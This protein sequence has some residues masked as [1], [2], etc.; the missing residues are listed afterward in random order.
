MAQQ[1][2]VPGTPGSKLPDILPDSTK[3]VVPEFDNLVNWFGTGRYS[4]LN[5]QDAKTVDLETIVMKY[6]GTNQQFSDIVILPIISAG[7]WST[8]I[9]PMER[10]LTINFTWKRIY[11]QN[12]MLDPEPELATAS[13]VSHTQ[14]ELK[15]TMTRW[16]KKARIGADYYKLKD[17][18]ELMNFQVIQLSTAA[19]NTIEQLIERTIITSKRYWQDW[20][21][22][23]GPRSNSVI[24]ASMDEIDLFGICSDDDKGFYKLLAYVRRVMKAGPFQASMGIFKQG[25]LDFLALTGDFETNSTKVGIEIAKS[26]LLSAG[27]SFKGTFG[28]NIAIYEVQAANNQIQGDGLSNWERLVTIG[29][30]AVVNGWTQ[31]KCYNGEQGTCRLSE[32]YDFQHISMDIDGYKTM[33]MKWARRRSLRFDEK[34]RLS[35]FLSNFLTKIFDVAEA[36]GIKIL[37]EAVDPYIW[38]SNDMK[39]DDGESQANN[40][41]HLCRYVGDFETRYFTLEQQA[42]HG[43]IAA[44]VIKRDLTAEDYSNMTKMA[45]LR[46]QLASPPDLDTSVVGLVLATAFMKD[47]IPHADTPSLT[48]RRNQLTGSPV[49]PYRARDPL[50]TSFSYLAEDGSDAPDVRVLW[51][52]YQD[53]EIDFHQ[54]GGTGQLT[55]AAGGV[56][57][58]A[59]RTVLRAQLGGEKFPIAYLWAPK[60][61]FANGGQ[62]PTNVLERSN[63]LNGNLP[64]DPS[65]IAGL[66]GPSSPLLPTINK[67]NYVQSGAYGGT[68]VGIGYAWQTFEGIDV[69]AVA[70]VNDPLTGRLLDPGS[71][72]L[73]TY[74]RGK[75]L[76]GGLRASVVKAPPMPYGYSSLSHMQELALRVDDSNGRG[77]GAVAQMALAGINSRLKY[78]SCLMKI[79]ADN[80]ILS[81]KYCPLFC[82]TQI[83][84][85]NKRYSLDTNIISG[86]MS[87]L[88]VRYPLIGQRLVY[89]PDDPRKDPN[90]GIYT[91]A[92]VPASLPGAAVP[93]A[94]RFTYALKNYQGANTNAF[95]SHLGNTAIANINPW[96]PTPV[97]VAITTWALFFEKYVFTNP[98][99]LDI[100]REKIGTDTTF[101]A[102]MLLSYQKNIQQP[103]LNLLRAEGKSTND[104]VVPGITVTTNRA[105][106]LILKEVTELI[107]TSADTNDDKMFRAAFFVCKYLNMLYELINVNEPRELTRVFL[108]S[109]KNEYT[110]KK[111]HFIQ[112]EKHSEFERDTERLQELYKIL[113]PQSSYW[114]NSG[115]VFDNR[116]FAILVENHMTNNHLANLKLA[117]LPISPANPRVPN[118]PLFL[119]LVNNEFNQLEQNL[120]VEADVRENLKSLKQAKFRM[121]GTL[122]FAHQEGPSFS[123]PEEEIVFADNYIDHLADDANG[124]VNPN[125]EDEFYEP[126]NVVNDRGNLIETKSNFV[127]RKYLVKRFKKTSNIT[128]QWARHPAMLLNFLNITEQSLNTLLDHGIPG[129]DDCYIFAQPWC[130]FT[131]S[132]GLFS[133]PGVGKT[134][135]NYEDACLY[136]DGEH[137]MWDIHFTA[138]YGCCFPHPDGFLMVSDIMYSKYHSGMDDNVFVNPDDFNPENIDFTKSGFIF[139]CGSAFTRDEMLQFAN[140]L[141]L[142]GRFT[143][144]ALPYNI[145]N[146]SQLIE[147][148]VQLWPSAL[149]YSYAWS[150]SH[151][152]PYTDVDNSSYMAE[153]TRRSV[154]G[155]MYHMRTRTRNAQ[156]GSWET[157]FEG[158]GHLKTRNPPMLPMFNGRITTKQDKNY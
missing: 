127:Y 51:V 27:D 23:Y 115:L 52:I 72:A 28:G 134:M 33:G 150:L 8:I 95:F 67:I 62:L 1:F 93:R 68:P 85:T 64:V 31:M 59:L 38:Y 74:F 130:L 77:W 120:P 132:M 122:G 112:S 133:A 70:A 5:P 73:T 66:G 57:N 110:T 43:E 4:P 128:N 123:K 40:G 126:Q 137:K 79:Y 19:W 153:K 87:P 117:S 21:L 78:D 82:R 49:I 121:G 99:L 29:R 63:Y 76:I 30:C 145:T 116:I 158:N 42:R 7:G 109:L 102:K 81:E 69:G 34:G 129:P 140:P 141:P 2:A 20:L 149:Y 155:N 58:V 55:S 89:G 22:N 11:F 36:S 26:R 88:F 44:N 71:L 154:S 25:I 108:E 90:H 80:A 50:V 35:P 104:I 146:K 39:V 98:E 100:V 61:C 144:K 17:G 113:S 147:N 13:Y 142:F 96:P 12:T 48:L 6:Q 111:L 84:E 10:S 103:Y 114:I 156:T 16:G 97:G 45:E 53:Q 119:G 14:E 94:N 83:T 41:Y 118:R 136:F 107:Q 151:M 54:D 131:M 135:Y 75:N 152:T 3:G 139:S 143:S 101:P 125:L 157:D 15:T 18:Q 86:Y 37:N 24:E 91:L 106:Y 92:G 32:L 124:R 9:A 105:N 65:Y 56:V 60:N 47:N 148:R 138:W 46:K